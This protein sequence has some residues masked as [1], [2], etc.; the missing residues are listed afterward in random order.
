M[1]ESSL[2]RYCTF[3]T[4]AGTFS[5]AVDPS[6]AVAAT[7]FGDGRALGRRLRGAK[8]VRD[9]RATSAVRSQVEAWFRGKRRDFS[10]ALSPAGS[11][12]QRR[13][14]SELRRIPFGDTRSYGEVARTVGSWRARSAAPTRPIPSALLFHATGSS[15]PTAR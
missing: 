14:W 7:A 6:G 5:V 13:V 2:F 15:G 11:S 1:K 4:P 12:F 8:L 9:E 10:V 3:K